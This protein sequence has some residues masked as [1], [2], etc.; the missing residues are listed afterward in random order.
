MKRP[1]TFLAVMGMWVFASASCA[2]QAASALPPIEDAIRVEAQK[3]PFAEAAQ[4]SL[5]ALPQK[6][7]KIVVLRFR[8]VAISPGPGGCNL[9]LS[10]RLNDAPITRRAS[11][12]RERLIG[13]TATFQF[14][15]EDT[16]IFPV[17]SGSRINLMYAPD[18]KTGDGMARNGLGATF[19]LDI[20][21]IARGVDGNTLHIQNA[22]Q[23]RTKDGSGDVLVETIEIGWLDKTLLP[24]PRNEVPRRGEISRSVAGDGLRLSLAK[25]G[26]FAVAAP[27]GPELRVEST[28]GMDPAAPSVLIADDQAREQKGPQL[29]RTDFGPRGFCIT[30]IWPTR[31]LSR[32]IEIKDGLV[33]WGEE[34]TNTGDKT[35][36][37][38][39]RHRLFLQ[40][41]S[42]RCLLA[43]NPDADALAGSAQNPT[44]FLESQARS[45]NGFGLTAESDWLRLLMA[46]RTSGGL[47]EIYSDTLALAPGSSIDFDLTLTPV[48]DGGGYWTFINALRK[49]WGVNGFCVDRPVFWKYARAGAE[50]PEERVRSSL[51]HLGP[52]Y[53][54]HSPWARAGDDAVTVRTGRYPKL[55]PDSPRAPGK[56]PDLDVEA[57]LSFA[58]REAGWRAFAQDVE[59]IHRVCPQVKVI[60]IAH[61]AM[62]VIYKPLAGRWPIAA[63]AIRTPEGTIFEVFHYSQA[64]LRDYVAKDWGVLYYSPRPGSSYLAELLGGVRR[65]MDE[66][67]SDGIYCDE[68]SWAFSG[69]H[70]SRYDYSRWDG[71]SADLDAEGN[72][73]R[74]KCDNAHVTESCQ[75]QM[76]HEVL[77]RGKFFL[78]NGAAAL[79]SVTELPIARFIEGGNGYGTM[80]GGHL[81]TVP[82]VFGN[83][84]DEK[85]K[86]GIFESVK[87]CLSLG[88]VYSPRAVNLLLDGPDNFV[89]KLY[90]ITIREIG[91]GW[92]T[93]EERVI[94]TVSRS[95]DW[96]G[97]DAD[98][99]LYRYS[100]NGEGMGAAAVVRGGANQKLDLNV[101]E[102]GLAIAEIVK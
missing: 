56:C 29:T 9:N 59:T 6:P 73:V 71:Y 2:G 68:F 33:R 91:P 37:M 15:G 65:S 12:G 35:I 70:Y 101:P 87:V 24:A 94:T 19:L 93:A 95:F 80:A 85:T 58:H 50:T 83:M 102:K 43:G 1:T 69:R 78:G 60:Q 98:I 4:V 36:G 97:R 72:V 3:V 5:P 11:G 28:V 67:K 48:R 18:T 89:C 75:L 40:G 74:L 57:F 49:R 20:S 32:T 41:D 13:R 52:I 63:E 61:P 51:G 99:R 14:A 64:H 53:V 42:A 23:H 77:R 38:P 45:G 31:K 25:G 54:A 34:W 26:G 16:R 96:P 62:E 55:P 92:V 66:C 100:P 30:A 7:E 10:L 47:S 8:A 79:R 46:M 17:F 86:Q 90:P 76:V 81:S 44:L 88:C 22:R 84:G 82:L 27:D 39:F 21:D